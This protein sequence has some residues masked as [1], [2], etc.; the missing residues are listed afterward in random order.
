[1]VRW[2]IWWQVAAAVMAAVASLADNGTIPHWLFPPP[3][4]VGLCA[5]SS[6]LSPMIVFWIGVFRGRP[7]RMMSPLI[8]SIG[9]SLTTFF[10]LMPS[11]S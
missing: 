5:W 1:M 4:V 3:F 8:A 2:L 10:A 7:V 11:V 6:I 9:L